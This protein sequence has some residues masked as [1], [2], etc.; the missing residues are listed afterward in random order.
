MI[1][2]AR[3]SHKGGEQ[4]IKKF[5]PNELNEVLMIISNVKACSLPKKISK[6]KGMKGRPL[7]NPIA[8]N[9]AF[10]EEFKK[11]GWK[12]A[13]ISI[14][15]YVPETREYHRGFREMDYVKNKLGVE[16]Q[17]GK[18]AF[19]VYDVCAK[20]TIFAKHE[21]IDAGI[22][23]VPMLNMANNMSS[24]VSYFEQVKTDLEERGVADLDIP[25]LIIGIDVECEIRQQSKLL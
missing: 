11:Y 15:T 22:E 17:F 19:M 24:G 20:M 14:E 10:E 4:F 5:H 9:K 6:E 21:I 2:V 3:Y 1:V 23:I 25:T 8:L 12:K 13:R 16:V 7:H 18:Y